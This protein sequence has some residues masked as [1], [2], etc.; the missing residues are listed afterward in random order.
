MTGISSLDKAF[1]NVGEK[2]PALV[3]GNLGVKI[4]CK[5]LDL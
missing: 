1:L 4:V 2:Y 3:K 5:V